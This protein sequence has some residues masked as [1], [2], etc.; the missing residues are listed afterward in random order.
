MQTVLPVLIAAP[1]AFAPGFFLVL[2]ALCLRRDALALTPLLNVAQTM[3]HFSFLAAVM[4]LFGVGNHTRPYV[5]VIFATL[6]I[7][8]LTMMGQQGVKALS[9]ANGIGDGLMLGLDAAFMGLAVGHIIRTWAQKQREL[10]GQNAKPR[11]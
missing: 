3:P 5:R 4:V 8:R 7:L 1:I 10:H 9:V 11:I 2:P 6:P